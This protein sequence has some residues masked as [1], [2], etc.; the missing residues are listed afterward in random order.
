VRRIIVVS[1]IGTDRFTAGYGAAK[2]AHERAMLAGPIPAAIVR[3]AQFHEFVSQL[4]EWGREDG[5][6]YLPKMRTQLVAARTVAETLADIATGR[7]PAAARRPNGAPILEIAGPREENLVEA[8]RLLAAHRGEQ[9]RIEGVSNPDDPDRALYES[10]ALLPGPDAILAG[11]T[12]ERW[13]KG[14][15]EGNSSSDR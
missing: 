3:A 7:G 12:F 9:V 13:L 11:P 4:R 10:G 6:I 1:I 5:T 15:V 14:Q 2:Q 8:A